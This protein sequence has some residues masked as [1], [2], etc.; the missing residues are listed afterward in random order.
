MNRPD[1]APQP[2]EEGPEYQIEMGVDGSD[3]VLAIEPP[4]DM[5][6]REEMFDALEEMGLI[7]EAVVRGFFE[8]KNLPDGRP[9]SEMRVSG[10]ALT[11]NGQTIVRLAH[12]SAEILREQNRRATVSPHMVT[13]GRRQFF[14]KSKLN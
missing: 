13:V 14:K 8:T 11:V 6:F 3:T 7:K 5:P 4:V 9:Y 10:E 12:K 2:Q 1:Q